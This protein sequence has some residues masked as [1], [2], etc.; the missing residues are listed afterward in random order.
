[1]GVT[2]RRHLL[3]AGHDVFGVNN[4]STGS[5]ANLAATALL[6]RFMSEN[7]KPTAAQL[8][9]MLQ[10]GRLS[11]DQFFDLAQE[12]SKDEM[13]KLAALLRRWINPPEKMDKMASRFYV[14]L[15]T[16]AEN[17]NEGIIRV[18]VELPPDA[19]KLFQ[20]ASREE[21]GAFAESAA[22]GFQ[23]AG[24]IVVYDPD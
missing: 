8:L 10:A 14:Y 2:S 17:S 7:Q 13:V 18:D 3:S 23:H 5:E 9:K 24:M 19:R 4:F 6:D 22:R 1:L 16:N 21:A 12:L 11:R 15:L 20:F